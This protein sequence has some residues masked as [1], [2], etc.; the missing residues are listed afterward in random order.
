[1]KRSIFTLF[2]A[3]CLF[4]CAIPVIVWKNPIPSFEERKEMAMELLPDSLFA[5]ANQSTYDSLSEAAGYD[6][7]TGNWEW[8]TED[9]SVEFYPGL[10]LEDPLPPYY[11]PVKQ[12][13]KHSPDMMMLIYTDGQP[14]SSVFIRHAPESGKIE[15]FRRGQT[16]EKVREMQKQI[17]AFRQ[18]KTQ[19][20]PICLVYCYYTSFVY[21]NTIYGDNMLLEIDPAPE[22]LDQPYFQ[23]MDT[24]GYPLIAFEDFKQAVKRWEY[25]VIYKGYMGEWKYITDY[26]PEYG[27]P[28]IPPNR[29]I[30]GTAGVLLLVGFIGYRIYHSNRRRKRK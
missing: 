24:G 4:A 5:H 15:F 20:S 1:M 21:G 13:K 19:N 22:S 12:V 29:W 8:K 28:E 6:P 2:L 23:S 10:I 27:D 14:L 16:P 30:F 18:I 11:F 17:E 25:I 26:L 7:E 3:V 9:W